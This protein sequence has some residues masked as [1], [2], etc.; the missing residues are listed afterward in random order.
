MYDHSRRTVYRVGLDSLLF[1][2]IIGTQY[3]ARVAQQT[4]N[5]WPNY[6]Q[7][8]TLNNPNTRIYNNI[9]GRIL[10]YLG[11]PEMLRCRKIH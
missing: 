4:T 9:Y 11:S 2:I 5:K 6:D 8:R 10:T 1:A 7:K 3:G